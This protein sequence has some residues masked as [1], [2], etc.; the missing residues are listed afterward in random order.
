MKA[1]IQ[2]QSIRELALLREKDE[3]MLS[4][5]ES[6]EIMMELRREVDSIRAEYGD[7]EQKYNGLVA[8]YN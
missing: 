3:L 8:L 7:Q 5:N 6:Y 2:G 4:I 1:Q